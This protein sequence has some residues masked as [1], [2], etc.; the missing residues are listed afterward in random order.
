MYLLLQAPLEGV[1]L[2]VDS[3]GHFTNW[4]GPKDGRPQLISRSCRKDKD[5]KISHPGSKPSRGLCHM[6]HLPKSSHI[7]WHSVLQFQWESKK[8]KTNKNKSLWFYRKKTLT[9]IIVSKFSIFQFIF[10]TV[11]SDKTHDFIC[12][13]LQ[14]SST[15]T[16]I[17]FLTF[18]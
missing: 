15:I 3:K 5:A 10:L 2:F 9:C 13:H 11:S 4:N 18:E 12:S 14:L 1:L 16:S 17:Y 7:S 6:C 8:N